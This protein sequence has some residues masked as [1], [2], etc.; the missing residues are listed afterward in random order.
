MHKMTLEEARAACAKQG[1][2]LTVIYTQKITRSG[3]GD[4]IANPGDCIPADK[5]DMAGR[6]V[7][8]PAK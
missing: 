7:S 4:E 8:P 1:G 3:V 2:F 6:Q 5:F